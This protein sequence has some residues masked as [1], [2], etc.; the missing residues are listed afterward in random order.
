MR[1][2]GGAGP[3]DAAAAR[4]GSRGGRLGGE[5]RF[6][7]GLYGGGVAPAGVSRRT[8][9]GGR[10]DVDRPVVSTRNGPDGGSWTGTW[11]GWDCVGVYPGRAAAAGGW[12]GR[13]GGAMIAVPPVL[14]G[15]GPKAAGSCRLESGREAW[16]EDREDGS[17]FLKTPFCGG[18]QHLAGAGWG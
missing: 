5:G 1:A 7:V 13:G 15:G 9:G 18:G 6:A 8:G 10:C 17:S 4:G 11:P 12:P 2:G 3:G 16:G 14:V